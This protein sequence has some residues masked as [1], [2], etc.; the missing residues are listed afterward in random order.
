MCFSQ[1]GRQTNGFGWSVTFLTA[2]RFQMVSFSM[3]SINRQAHMHKAVLASLM[4]AQTTSWASP[5][6]ET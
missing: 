5:N 2:R 3:R 6:M 4:L 1:Q